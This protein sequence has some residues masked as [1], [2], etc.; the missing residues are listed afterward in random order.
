MGRVRITPTE[1]LMLE[2][3]AARVRT[4][5]TCW[6]FNSRH[7]QAA[8]SLSQ[9]GY[10]GFKAGIVERTIIVWFTDKGFKKMSLQKDYE[11]PFLK[12]L[13]RAYMKSRDATERAWLDPDPT[14]V[15]IATKERRKF[16]ALLGV[17][18]A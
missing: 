10:V 4:G 3:L 7:R 8:G 18:D 9:K 6:T 1:E 16:L 11:F 15:D 12:E 2:V 13:R 14:Y 5:E 17:T